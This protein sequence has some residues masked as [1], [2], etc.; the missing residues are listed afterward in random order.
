VA[1][2]LTAEQVRQIREAPKGQVCDVAAHLGV[3]VKRAYTI[4]YEANA[5]GSREPVRPNKP[6]V[7]RA[8]DTDGNL[9]YVGS[10]RNFEVRKRQHKY[11]PK[12]GTS[13]RK[14][15]DRWWGEVARWE[16]TEYRTYRE[17]LA[18]EAEA[19]RTE[20][21]RYNQQPEPQQP[22]AEPFMGDRYDDIEDYLLFVRRALRGA[23]AR[24]GAAD[25]DALAQMATLREELEDCIAEA[26]GALRNNPD[27]PAS[28]ADIGKA[29]GMRREAAFRRY[30]KVGGLRKPAGQ[31]GNWR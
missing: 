13:G 17:A 26:V 31:P 18:A 7:Y 21:P 29:L 1:T 14:P 15:A 5:N 12:P 28:W 16:T 24:V 20:K 2:E 27:L 3:P 22:A 23:A 4:R 6:V 10:T 25:C 9:L 19:I 8:Y 11:S 30:R